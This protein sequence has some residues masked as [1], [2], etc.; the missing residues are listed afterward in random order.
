MYINPY[1][2][3]NDKLW[4]KANFHVHAGTGPNTCGVNEIDD[5]LLAYKDKPSGYSVISISNHDLLTDTSSYAK[6]HAMTLINGYEF[7]EPGPHMI[8]IGTDKVVLDSHQTAIEDCK[9]HGGFTVL[10]HPNWRF[11]EYWPHN[12]IDELSGF[13]GIEIINGI[14]FRNPGSELATDTWDY[15]LNSGRAVWGFGNDDFHIWRDIARCWNLI[16]CENN[17]EAVINAIKH[18]RFYVSTG[19]ILGDFS[20]LNGKLRLSAHGFETYV[21][22]NLYTF[23][24]DNGKILA[25]QYG[26]HGEYNL[27]GSESYVRVRVLSDYGSMLWTQP[28]YDDNKLKAEVQQ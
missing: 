2:E 16:N 28:V 18:C 7:T 24:G 22:E 27:V 8:C 10:C 9:A 25:E 23:I 5:V 11:K 26:D 15:I 3:I 1:E 21:N 17:P 19:L 14:V 4:L 6:R 20:F 13:A 12:K